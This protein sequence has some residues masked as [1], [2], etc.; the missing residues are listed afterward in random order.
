VDRSQF[1]APE[2]RPSRAKASHLVKAGNRG[3]PP[4]H[5]VKP[6]Q[7][8]L[9]GAASPRGPGG[10]PGGGGGGGGTG[11]DEVAGLTRGGSLD[12]RLGMLASPELRRLDAQLSAGS[13]SQAALG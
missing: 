6:R 5:L 8:P 13:T 7:T 4:S 12:A 10:T 9:G 3:A 1:V 11:G 2:P